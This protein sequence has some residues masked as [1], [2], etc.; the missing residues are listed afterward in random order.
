MVHTCTP[1]RAQVKN[2]YPLSEIEDV[3]G[4]RFYDHFHSR[5][6]C[7]SRKHE[8]VHSCT[9]YLLWMLVTPS[10]YSC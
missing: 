10:I 5:M 6:S 4:K 8:T 7:L 1:Y 3:K 2:L 9:L